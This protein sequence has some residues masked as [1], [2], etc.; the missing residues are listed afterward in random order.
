MRALGNIYDELFDWRLG[1][2]D[3]PGALPKLGQGPP[4]KHFRV[5][6]APVGPKHGEFLHP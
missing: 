3:G 5:E 1:S 2:R 6:Y 4:E